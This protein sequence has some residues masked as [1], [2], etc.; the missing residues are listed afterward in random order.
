MRRLIPAP[1]ILGGLVSAEPAGDG[2]Y[3]GV[4]ATVDAQ[5]RLTFFSYT[6]DTPAGRITTEMKLHSFGE[7]VTVKAP[8]ASRTMN[9]PDQVYELF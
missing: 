7:P 9:A 1:G 5:G 8:P 4:A 6:F 3:T 2:R